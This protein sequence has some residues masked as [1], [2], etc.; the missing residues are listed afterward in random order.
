MDVILTGSLA[1]LIA[2]LG[3]GIGALPILFTHNIQHRLQGIFLGFG[4]G[5]MLAATSFSLIVPGTEAA[6]AQ[7][8]SETVAAL[9]VGM[10]I[11]LGSAALWFAH[12]HFPHEH[13]FKG[14]EGPTLKNFKRIW[15]FVI[16]ITLHNFPEGLAVGVGF[17][18]SNMANGIALALGIGVQNVP[19]GLVVALGLRELNYSIAYAL[20]IAFI[21]GLVEPVGGAIGAGIVSVA[22]TFLP[23]AMAFAAGAMLF[24]IVD[25]IIPEIARKS[26]EQEGTLGIVAGF[27]CMMFLDI[28]LG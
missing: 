23:W 26:Y 5:V 2:G 9:I 24:V 10:G 3:T 18:G 20:G 15:L 8:N 16:A 12:N 28:A 14:K 4:G 19:E 1:S 21:T 11:I 27:V 13:F 6:L 7:G 22:Q 25:E 17:G